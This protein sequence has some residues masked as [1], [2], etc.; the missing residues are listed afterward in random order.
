MSP[1]LPQLSL[2]PKAGYDTSIGL[3]TSIGLVH[4]QNC[5]FII[6]TV[7]RTSRDC[8]NSI[9]PLAKSFGC[10]SEIVFS[11]PTGFSLLLPIHYSCLWLRFPHPHNHQWPSG[12]GWEMEKWER[13]ARAYK[14]GRMG[15]YKKKKKVC[16]GVGWGCTRQWADLWRMG[17]G[18]GWVKWEQVGKKT[19]RGKRTEQKC[20][21][22]LE[23]EIV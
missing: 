1:Y 5:I 2:K 3:G 4:C 23:K 6:T 15:N 9:S 22:V 11:V 18:D 21:A 8:R 13:R 20:G 14:V 19:L 17:S 10:I 16:G 7:S 12:L